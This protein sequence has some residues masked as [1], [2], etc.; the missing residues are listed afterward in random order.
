VLPVQYLLSGTV[1][2]TTGTST[3]PRLPASRFFKGRNPTVTASVS[4]TVGLWV[5]DPLTVIMHGLGVVG[6]TLDTG[7]GTTLL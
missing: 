1:F 4:L 6:S 5:F 7:T 3:H 2:C